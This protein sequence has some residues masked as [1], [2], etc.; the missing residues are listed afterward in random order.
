MSHTL[1]AFVDLDNARLDEQREEMTRIMEAGH[2]PFCPENLKLYHKSPILKATKFWELSANQWPYEHTRVHLL[3]ILKVHAEKLSDLP[4]GSGEE[5][6]EL[7]AWAEKHFQ[8]PGGGFAMR[9]GD[10]DYSAGTVKHI[11]AQFFVPSIEDPDFQPVRF[12]IGKNPVDV[13]K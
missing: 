10:T 9:F 2:C 1:P 4:A 6:L 8:A 13:R 7:M 12:K 11:H 3:A 5:L